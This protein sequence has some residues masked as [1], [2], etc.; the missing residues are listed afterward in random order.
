LSYPPVRNFRRFS[1]FLFE[2]FQPTVAEHVDGAVG[3]AHHQ[4]HRLQRGRGRQL[5]C[6]R[7]RQRDAPRPY[8]VSNEGDHFDNIDV[9]TDTILIKY[10][11]RV[12]LN[13]D[14]FVNDTDSILFSTN[15]EP[16]ASSWWTIG[17]LDYDGL[18][19]DSDA[20]LFSTFYDPNLARI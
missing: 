6:R 4:L 20:I 17:D 3:F 18:F 14:G 9:D 10:T 19:T 8:G 7:R 11:H 13:L 1:H 5:R 15:Y 12:G 16:N 2:L